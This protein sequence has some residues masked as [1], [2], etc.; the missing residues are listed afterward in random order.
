MRSDRRQGTLALLGVTVAVSVTVAMATIEWHLHQT[1]VSSTQWV[2]HTLEVERHFDALLT[3]LTDAD[4]NQRGFLLVSDSAYL[5]P[6]R[7]ATAG[8][9]G[10]IKELIHLTADNDAQQVRLASL[11]TLVSAKA[12]ELN[13]TIDLATGGHT[14]AAVAIVASNRGRDSMDQIRQGIQD[15]IAEEERLLVRRTGALNSEAAQ[16]QYL[17]WG[18]VA[19]NAA[20]ML[21]LL[22]AMARM[23]RLESMVTVCA[24][25]KTIQFD[26]EWITFEE[27]LW[28]RF[29]TRVS[30]GVSPSQAA[31]LAAEIDRIEPRP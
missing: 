11:A 13:Q 24:W 18:L 8:I 4:T 22:L 5:A 23:R 2:T 25:S 6:Y 29:H 14:D 16:L 26:G 21:A 15:G 20:A 17:A 28:R 1:I 3:T 30:H 7:A 19:V 12:A 27:Y 10:Q 31:A 9:D